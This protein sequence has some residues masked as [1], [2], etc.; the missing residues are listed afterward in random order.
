[1]T[2][3]Q[4]ELLRKRQ[5]LQAEQLQGLQE[6]AAQRSAHK[7]LSSFTN[8]IL[9]KIAAVLEIPFGELSA[10]KSEDDPM[11]A[12]REA[13]AFSP[14]GD[15]YTSSDMMSIEHILKG[16]YK[17][18]KVWQRYLKLLA[19]SPNAMLFFRVDGWGTV[20]L[21]R[22]GTITPMPGATRVQ[23]V[24]NENSQDAYIMHLSQFMDNVK[25]D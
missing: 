5:Q 21:F 1:M 15:A 10:I 12:L 19:K 11:A 7:T 23:I 22:D 16:T 25:N 3:K 9:D 8:R 24:A 20:V 4:S 6:Q 13:Y 14:F 17:T 2:K 18:H